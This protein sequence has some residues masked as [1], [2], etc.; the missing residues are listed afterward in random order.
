VFVEACRI[1]DQGTPMATI[2]AN[3][4]RSGTRQR[5]AKNPT[6]DASQLPAEAAR[7]VDLPVARADLA[8]ARRDFRIARRRQIG[9][10]VVLDLMA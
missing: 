7:R 1:M 10:E 6:D 3:R 9:E 5:E 2:F 4:R 8:H